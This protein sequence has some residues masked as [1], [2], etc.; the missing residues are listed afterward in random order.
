MDSLAMRLARLWLQ[1]PSLI[2]KMNALIDTVL[3]WAARTD[4]AAA[5]PQLHQLM[6]H[7][8]TTRT[9]LNLRDVP[10]LAVMQGWP[11]PEARQQL[12]L[13][14]ID[15]MIMHNRGTGPPMPCAALAPPPAPLPEAELDRHSRVLAQ[16]LAARPPAE[17]IAQLK[18]AAQVWVWCID[19][20]LI[21][22][23]A[24]ANEVFRA[25]WGPP[26][27]VSYVFALLWR[28][29]FWTG[30]GQSAFTE[31]FLARWRA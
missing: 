14:T 4:L 19:P 23:D 2:G 9:D 16:H 3:R 25:D 22:A 27:F 12:F 26:E 24:I 1:A 7:A 10:S 5:L 28:L 30:L 31:E 8:R 29:V 13:W 11:E 17:A 15:A 18:E 20:A 6:D 21:T